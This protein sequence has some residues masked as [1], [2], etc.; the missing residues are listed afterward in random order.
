[1][2][3]ASGNRGYNLVRYLVLLLYGL[4]ACNTI[5]EES[6]IDV[7]VYLGP[8]QG[9][10]IKIKASDFG[11]ITRRICTKI[12]DDGSYVI[13][14]WTKLP[15]PKKK[16]SAEGRSKTKL[17]EG[18]YY[19]DDAPE[20]T[21]YRYSLAAEN[22][23]LI[24]NKGKRDEAVYLDLINKEWSQY[25][26]SSTG[27]IKA[28]Y[29]IVKEEEKVVLGKLRKLVHVKYSFDLKDLHYEELY[30][31]ASGLGIIYTESL[32]PGSNKLTS[33]LVEE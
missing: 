17:P 32:A 30:V 7:L 23:K 27:K 5:P 6:K 29:L 21:M 11:T 18:A 12:N 19:W 25:V 20:E 10:M 28:D 1:M 33:T 4:I 2:D 31:V 15:K 8:S 13:E 22:G 24:F 3:P 26:W 14:E 9:E 16:S